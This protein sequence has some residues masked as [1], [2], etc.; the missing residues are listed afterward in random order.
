MPDVP[1][2]AIVAGPPT[3]LKEI[4]EV[5]GMTTTDLPYT[6]SASRF[7]R[8]STFAYSCLNVLMVLFS[9]YLFDIVQLSVLIS[10]ISFDA[11]V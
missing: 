2:D 1:A 7:T 9:C 3:L 4:N 10:T 5:D 8:L 6:L 11:F